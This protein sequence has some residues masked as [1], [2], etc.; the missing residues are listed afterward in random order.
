[1]VAPT[2]GPKP[3]PSDLHAWMPSQPQPRANGQQASSSPGVHTGGGG[4]HV[5]VAVDP[6]IPTL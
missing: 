2:H 5:S 1:M 3:E 4:T 6:E